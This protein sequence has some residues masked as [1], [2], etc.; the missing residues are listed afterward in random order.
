MILSGAPWLMS[1]CSELQMLIHRS[2]DRRTCEQASE[3]PAAL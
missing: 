3:D 1:A 2:E